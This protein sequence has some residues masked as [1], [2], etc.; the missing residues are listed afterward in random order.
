MS[1]NNTA[2]V[3]DYERL[4]MQNAPMPD[5][6]SS[7]DQLMYQALC[8]LYTRYR[9]KTISRE[10]A[11]NEKRQLLREHEK[12][13]YRWAMGDRYVQLVRET[14]GA[15]CEYRKNRTIENAD[16]LL[17]RVDGVLGGE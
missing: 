15:R 14:E 9:L 8:L 2:V 17:K 3:L 12:F 5:G 1:E 10:Q 7:P 16:K 6:L 11:S 13:L 4:A